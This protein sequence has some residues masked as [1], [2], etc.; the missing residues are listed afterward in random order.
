MGV[1]ATATLLASLAVDC[2]IARCGVQGA[3]LTR[4][5]LSP[6]NLIQESDRRFG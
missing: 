1:T 2:F 5:S 4:S 3:R 6:T